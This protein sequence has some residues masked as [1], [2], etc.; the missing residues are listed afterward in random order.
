MRRHSRAATACCF[1]LFLAVFIA[2]KRVLNSFTPLTGSMDL[3]ILFFILPGALAGVFARRGREL[4][5]LLGALVAAPVCLVL[6]HLW[7]GAGRSF[8]QELAWIFSALFWCS[9]GSLCWLFLLTLLRRRDGINR[10]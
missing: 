6:L 2:Q 8:W 1:I 9:F 7:G 4:K 10:L 3:G 5:P